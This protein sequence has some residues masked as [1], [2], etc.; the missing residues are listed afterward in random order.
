MAEV[1][2]L[3]RQVE[4]LQSRLVAMDALLM[5][6]NSYLDA[7]YLAVQPLAHVG[8]FQQASVEARL[9]LYTNNNERRIFDISM[10]PGQYQQVK[11][12]SPFARIVVAI[13]EPRY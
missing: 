4:A 9:M 2:L 6:Q 13:I 7:P 3:K 12:L 8:V 10:N 1:E 11:P 5:Q